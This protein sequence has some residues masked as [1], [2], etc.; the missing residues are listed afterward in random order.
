MFGQLETII[1]ELEADDVSLEKSFD[2]YNKG[3]NLLK[4]CGKSIDEVEKKVLVL[5][6]DGSTHEF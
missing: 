3:M 2:L 6:E 4:E 1:G 5:D